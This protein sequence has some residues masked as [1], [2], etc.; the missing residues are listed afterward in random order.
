ME[1]QVRTP[2]PAYRHEAANIDNVM[3]SE[4]LPTL[5][6]SIAASSSQIPTRSASLLRSSPSL[7]T[8]VA[9]PD[10]THDGDRFSLQVGDRTFTTC[11][12]TLMQAEYFSRRFTEGR[13]LSGPND[14]SYF[15]DQDGDIFKDILDYLRDGAFPILYDPL[16]GFNETR[17]IRILAQARQLGIPKLETWI[18]DKEYIGGIKTEYR[19][20]AWTGASPTSTIVTERGGST[21]IQQ[22]FAWGTR[23]FDTCPRGFHQ[24]TMN[25]NANC[26]RAGRISGNARGETDILKRVQTD[27]KTLYDYNVFLPRPDQ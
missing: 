13:S 16:T 6:P 18:K 15:L 12:R 25:C 20:S 21:L 24:D 10:E 7:N 14:N 27:V 3:I 26:R 1:S 2:S 23:R 11:K 8:G 22:D 19:T 9:L 5:L 17:Y 4:R